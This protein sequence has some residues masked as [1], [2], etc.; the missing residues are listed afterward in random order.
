MNIPRCLTCEDKTYVS[1]QALENIKDMV[2]YSGKYEGGVVCGNCPHVFVF[3]HVPPE[4]ENMSDDRWVVVNVDSAD[5]CEPSS[6]RM[7][8]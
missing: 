2:F 6:K 5:S 7:C 4:Y 1:Y 3:A 8:L